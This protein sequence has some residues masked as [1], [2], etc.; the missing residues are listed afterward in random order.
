MSRRSIWLRHAADSLRNDRASH[1]PTGENF[2]NCNSKTELFGGYALGSILDLTGSANVDVECLELTD[3][4][5]CTRVGAGMPAGERCQ[6]NFPLSDYAQNG[7]VTN[8]GTK[9]LLL[10]NLDIHGLTSRGIIGAVGGEIT[11]DHVRIAFNGGA[12]WDFDDGSGAKSTSDAVVHASHLIVEWNGC[13][14]EYPIAHAVPAF[15]CFDQDSGGYGDGIGTP[16]TALSF[17]CDHCVFRYNTQDGL[18]LLHVSGSM[19]SVTNSNSYGNMGQQWKMG[20][21]RSV[22]FI[23]NVTVH[24]CRRLSESFSGAP[25]GYHRYLSQFCRAAGD[26]IAFSVNDAG[27]YIF[28]NNS[29][30]GYGATSYDIACSGTCSKA[31]IVFQN[32]LHAGY[33][34]PAS[35]ALPGL[36]YFT[37]L[38]R[39]PFLARDHNIYF[40]MRTCPFGWTEHCSDPKLASLPGWRGEASLDGIDFHLT[41]TSDAHGAG[42]S[43]SGVNEDHDGVKRPEN[44]P[45]D[46]GAFQFVH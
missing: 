38:P 34:D 15:S 28:E 20:P 6:S 1:A 22:R 9:N 27:T 21:M 24:N 2:Q 4:S 35:G 36:F 11:A 46:I 10:K 19:I 33:K 43:L 45:F 42:V 44:S 37:G 31:N 13:N 5:Q 26:G 40:N 17:T 25:A 41:S 8:A 16:D 14:E 32:N 23:N 12:G 18:D 29:F 39:N 30:A 7:I 3:H